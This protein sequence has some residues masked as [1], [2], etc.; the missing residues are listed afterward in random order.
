MVSATIIVENTV[1]SL[2][3]DGR[4]HGVTTLGVN[5]VVYHTWGELLWVYKSKA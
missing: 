3:G 1:F 4:M 2:V 5:C